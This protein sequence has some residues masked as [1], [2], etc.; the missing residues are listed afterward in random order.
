L[1]ALETS[2]SSAARGMGAAAGVLARDAAAA[3]GAAE[4]AAAA[5]ARIESALGDS[6]DDLLR[7]ASAQ[8]EQR[9][10]VLQSA[11]VAELLPPLRAVSMQMLSVAAAAGGAAAGAAAAAGGSAQP[12]AAPLRLELPD[13]AVRQLADA[14]AGDGEAR[15]RGVL[16]AAEQWSA[17]GER[18]QRL[19]QQLRRL[20]QASKA[21]AARAGEL[22]ASA[23]RAAEAAAGGSGAAASATLLA[24]RPVPAGDDER[25]QAARSDAYQSMLASLRPVD[26][27]ML[28]PAS[29][30]SIP[31]WLQ[32]APEQE[33]EPSLAAG[34]PPRAAA[35]GSSREEP[36][37]PAELARAASSVEPRP[38]PPP[39][40][41]AASPSQLLASGLA[42][43]RA[44][45]AEAEAGAADTHF[46]AA[47]QLLGRAATLCEAS[48]EAGASAAASAH[49]N[50]GNA[51]LA[52]ARLALQ[53]SG[54][55]RLRQAEEWLV[56]A[57]RRYRAALQLSPPAQQGRALQQWG[58][59]LALR[60]QL[61]A[62]AAPEDG[63]QLFAAAAEKFS[64]AAA[65]E[66]PPAGAHASLG[67]AL[68]ERADCLARGARLRAGAGSR[69]TRDAQTALQGGGLC[70]ARRSARWRRRCGEIRAIR[71]RLKFWPAATLS[72][73]VASSQVACSIISLVVALPRPQPPPS[74]RAR[75]ASARPAAPAPCRCR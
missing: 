14:I 47:V 60:G 55:E 46:A 17:L 7:R 39:D 16:L 54:K 28:P 33:A 27:A 66:Q 40:D 4:S 31:A 51:L 69:L 10:A 65:L 53:S 58:A 59:A 43:L 23:Q 48:P 50:C 25:D 52:R 20:L 72:A 67:A 15:S 68:V 5:T 37:G 6:L 42:A 35:V 34:E 64:A 21:Q 44:G 70:C 29:G 22:D 73:S 9:D 13:A 3:S 32:G 63:A 19:E 74:G 45:R 75:G 1:G 41:A 38:R 2:L 18:L 61:L 12:P 71:R 24:E 11:L 56:Q 30:R 49:G 57:G 8:A 36:A 26:A 62:A